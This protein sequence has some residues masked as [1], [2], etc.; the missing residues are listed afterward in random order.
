MSDYKIY[1]N[2]RCSKSRQTLA[3]LEAKGEEP[4]IIKYLENAP[5][6]D[7]IWKILDLLGV[8]ASEIVRT[9]EAIYKELNLKGASDEELVAAIVANP[10]LLERPIVLHDGKAIIGRPP[11]KVLE[12]L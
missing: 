2:P 7:E 5:S 1:H 8:G 11:E 12:L 4:E 9:G 3:I 10:I 6:E